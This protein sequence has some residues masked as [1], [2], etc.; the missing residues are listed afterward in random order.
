MLLACCQNLITHKIKATKQCDRFEGPLPGFIP[1][2]IPVRAHLVTT[3]SKIWDIH[4]R[5]RSYIQQTWFTGGTAWYQAA[6]RM[7][8]PKAG[9]SSLEWYWLNI[10]R[11]AWSGAVSCRDVG[12]TRQFSA[13]KPCHALG[14]RYRFWT[15]RWRTCVHSVK[16]QAP[17]VKNE[18]KCFVRC[19]SV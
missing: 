11:S 4:L 17:S 9:R 15:V 8:R 5:A 6:Q 7:K 3:P 12:A 1:V 19:G 2:S 16:R 14:W 10:S 18:G 13:L